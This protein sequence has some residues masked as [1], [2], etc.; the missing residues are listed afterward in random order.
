V[1]VP[2]RQPWVFR[3][4]HR[5]PRPL[6]HPCPNPT[7]VPNRCSL[8]PLKPETPEK[9]LLLVCPTRRLTPQVVCR[10]R[11]RFQL[12]NPSSQKPD[13]RPRHRPQ[14]PGRV[15]AIPPPG[16]ALLPGLLGSGNHPR[17]SKANHPNTSPDR[18]TAAYLLQPIYG[19]TPLGVS[20]QNSKYRPATY[21]ITPAATIAHLIPVWFS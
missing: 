2:D 21:E 3:R 6:S 12:P 13:C 10:I 1:L 8:K 19:L 18:L 11:P 15:W 7:N 20:H 17:S 5:L 16:T 14:Q 9:A 4:I